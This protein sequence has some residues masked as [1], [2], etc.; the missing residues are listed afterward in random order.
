MLETRTL[1]VVNTLKLAVEGHCGISCTDEE[2]KLPRERKLRRGRK[3]AL[4]AVEGIL[5]RSS[6]GPVSPKELLYD[7]VASLIS[8]RASLREMWWNRENDAVFKKM[9]AEY[10]PI[11][12]PVIYNF[13]GDIPKVPDGVGRS[14]LSGSAEFLKEVATGLEALGDCYESKHLSG[15]PTN[16]SL[17]RVTE[18]VLEGQREADNAP[19]V[20]DASSCRQLTDKSNGETNLGSQRVGHSNRVGG[21]KNKGKKRKKSNQNQGRSEQAKQKRN[22]Y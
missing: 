7:N 4:A 17:A 14:P 16:D 8:E 10:Q 6:D 3:K 19:F 11:P 15:S 12:F 1:Q 20:H 18:T 2:S 13:I 22:G 9:G 5:S 21:I